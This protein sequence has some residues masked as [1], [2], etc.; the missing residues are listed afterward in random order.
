VNPGSANNPKAVHRQ[1][2]ALGAA[3]GLGSATDDVIGVLKQPLADHGRVLVLKLLDVLQSGVSIECILDRGL[4]GWIGEPL[5]Q[6]VG[7][8]EE[9]FGLR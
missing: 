3:V 2:I 9:V 8:C 7:E 6:L 4:V 1:V 5:M